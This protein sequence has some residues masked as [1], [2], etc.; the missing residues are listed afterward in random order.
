MLIFLITGSLEDRL[1]GKVELL[2]NLNQYPI[3]AQ[4]IVCGLETVIVL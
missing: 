2:L 3:I 4:A 1:I